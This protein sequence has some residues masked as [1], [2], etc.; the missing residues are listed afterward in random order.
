MRRHTD[1]GD[2]PG[3]SHGTQRDEASRAPGWAVSVDWRAATRERSDAILESVSSIT[4]GYRIRAY[5]NGPQRRLLDRW[6]GAVRWL[7]NTALEIR[8]AVYRERR[9]T[10]TGKEL[11]RW[12]TQW[13]RTTWHEWL[14]EIPA[15]ALTQCLRDQDAAFRNFYAHRARYPRFK[16]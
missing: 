5:P 4:R 11:S 12:L 10:L 7:W 13:K 9:L 6:L 16:R 1:G 8:S 15:T 3:S 2:A 14:A